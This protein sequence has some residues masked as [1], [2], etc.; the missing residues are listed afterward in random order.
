MFDLPIPAMI[1]PLTDEQYKILKEIADKVGKPV[2]EYTLGMIKEI[3]LDYF[4]AS[5]MGYRM[6]NPD[7]HPGDQQN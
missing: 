5:L 2:A 3:L 4:N 1:L 7:P 6:N